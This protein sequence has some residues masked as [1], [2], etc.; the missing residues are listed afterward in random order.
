MGTTGR[1]YARLRDT[2]TRPIVL[3]YCTVQ[4][5]SMKIVIS[6]SRLEIGTS[7]VC[8]PVAAR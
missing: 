6:L 8:A 2:F 3:V 4:A 1:G 7:I 5:T